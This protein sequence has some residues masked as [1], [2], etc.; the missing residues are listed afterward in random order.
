MNIH[1]SFTP[2]IRDAQQETLKEPNLAN[3]GL[4]GMIRDLE[5]KTDNVMYFMDQIWIA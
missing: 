2:Q 5:L 1:S 4:R 3:E